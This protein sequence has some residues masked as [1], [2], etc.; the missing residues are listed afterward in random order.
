VARRLLDGAE[1]EIWAAIID[2]AKEGDPT[3]MRL[4]AERCEPARRRSKVIVCPQIEELLV[5]G[6]D[7]EAITRTLLRLA[8]AGEID[9]N[10]ADQLLGL[11]E[12]SRRLAAKTTDLSTT[13]DGDPAAA[14]RELADQLGFVVA[15]KVN[16]AQ[17]PANGN[18]SAVG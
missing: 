13:L 6:A 16:G 5:E 2:K 10:D 18:G 3:A 15:P 8:V 7:F 17:A 11:I 14:L 1:P 12:T 4:C 9:A